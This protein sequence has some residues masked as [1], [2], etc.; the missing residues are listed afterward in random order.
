MMMMRRTGSYIG[1][2][3]RTKKRKEKK[4]CRTRRGVINSTEKEN[5]L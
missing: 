2:E 1:I 4:E 5:L 3:Q